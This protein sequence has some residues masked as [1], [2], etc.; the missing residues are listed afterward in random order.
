MH[1]LTTETLLTWNGS[2]EAEDEALATAAAAAAANISAFVGVCWGWN[3]V[4]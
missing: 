1:L 2:D 4:V 3:V